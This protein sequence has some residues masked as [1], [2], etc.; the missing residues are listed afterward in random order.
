[1]NAIDLLKALNREAERI[2]SEIDGAKDER[3]KRA[4][5]VELAS[6]LAAQA[7]VEERQFRSGALGG[8][9]QAASV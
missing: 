9:K 6:C 4:F 5:L 1:M 7:T 2:L 8:T 3:T